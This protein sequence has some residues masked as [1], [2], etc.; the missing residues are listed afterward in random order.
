LSDLEIQTLASI[1]L[2]TDSYPTRDLNWL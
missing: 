1:D 2:E